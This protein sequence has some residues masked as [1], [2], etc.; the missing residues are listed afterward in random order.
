MSRKYSKVVRGSH[1]ALRGGGANL[2]G[3]AR[4]VPGAHLAE[5]ERR[6]RVTPLGRRSPILS[7]QGGLGGRA[8]ES[9]RRSAHSHAER[10]QGRDPAAARG[11]GE[12]DQPWDLRE[13]VTHAA[14][15]ARRSR[16]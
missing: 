14:C 13:G 9:H 2:D 12:D 1:C 5:G 4:L 8:D 15:E 6:V 16:E 3:L 7:G 11:S 10:I